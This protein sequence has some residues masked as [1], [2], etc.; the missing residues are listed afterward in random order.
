[1]P[2]MIWLATIVVAIEG[3]WDDF[4]VLMTLQMVNGVVGYFEEKSAVS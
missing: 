2:F 3:D 1:M 4:G